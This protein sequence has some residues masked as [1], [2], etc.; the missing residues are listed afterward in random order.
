MVYVNVN[1]NHKNNSKNSDKMEPEK[2]FVF[3]NGT[4]V[5]DLS[6]SDQVP[7]K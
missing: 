5:E 4:L 2:K 6:K 3:V 1:H 7:K